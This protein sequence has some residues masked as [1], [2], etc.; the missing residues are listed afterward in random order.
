[1][2]KLLLAMLLVITM[3]GAAFG[4]IVVDFYLDNATT[5]TDK[6]AEAKLIFPTC[7]KALHGISSEWLNYISTEVRIPFIIDDITINAQLY[8]KKKNGEFD[9]IAEVKD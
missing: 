3:C 2:K 6:T 5:V 9:L 7:Y 8:T 4:A 1:M